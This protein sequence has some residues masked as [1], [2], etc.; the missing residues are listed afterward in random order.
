MAKECDEYVGSS[1][2][3]HISAPLIRHHGP[4]TTTTTLG[5]KLALDQRPQRNV[6]PDPKTG[7]SARP[8]R[9]SIN[10]FTRVFRWAGKRQTGPGNEVE[11]YDSN[12]QLTIQC[13]AS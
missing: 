12:K 2:P 3:G 1:P 5:S 4:T 8:L 10:L 7:Y 9:G 6:P 13:G 11:L